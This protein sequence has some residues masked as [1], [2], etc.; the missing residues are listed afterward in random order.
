MVKH[1]FLLVKGD[2]YSAL[3]FEEHFK[4]Q[5]VYEQMIKD[6]LKCKTFESDEYYI[7]VHIKE[8]ESIDP[9]F[10]TFI[11]NEIHDYD[12]SKHYDFIEVKPI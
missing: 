6:N 9:K 4:A 10:I 8:F 7:D 3:H 1:I 5:E 11:R 2:D 12:A